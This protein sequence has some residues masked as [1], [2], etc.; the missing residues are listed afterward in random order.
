M[1][2]SMS[3]HIVQGGRPR[4][5][6]QYVGEGWDQLERQPSPIPHIPQGLQDICEVYVAE[7]WG[8]AV[9]VR[10]VHVVQQGA[11]VADSS[12][13]RTF[14]YVHVKGIGHDPAV[15]E[16]RL[17]PH[18]GGFVEPVEHVG[19]VAVPT[20][21]CEVDPERD[22]VL[23]GFT[24]SL[25]RPLPLVMR[26][27]DGLDTR[28]RSRGDDEEGSSEL[29]REPG[30]LTQINQ[31]SV[32]NVLVGVGEVTFGGEVRAHG[33][34]REPSVFGELLY[35]LR[36]IRL[37]LH[38]GLDGVVSEA[39]EAV[40]GR[41][42]VLALEADD[43]VRI[44]ELLLHPL[45]PPADKP[46]LQDGEQDDDG[47]D[48]GDGGG[49]R[50]SPRLAE[51]ALERQEAR[52]YGLKVIVLDEGNG[53]EKLVPGREPRDERNGQEAWPAQGQHDAE[54]DLQFVRAVYAGC[55][56]EVARQSDEI[57]AQQ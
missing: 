26:I 23:A 33:T 30:D 3:G 56:L 16:A 15:R 25:Y 12:W 57:G 35:P 43:V 49:A 2:Y 27:G 45:K 7:A 13:D 1:G 36:V 53:E 19:A 29:G 54:Q 39:G 24:Y 42:D 8:E 32:S 48:Y 5:V 50:E 46:T 34:D 10:E 31:G 4:L 17:P 22:G 28:V 52:R 55:V 37:R 44:A 11:E 47:Q 21:Q 51:V 38:F 6:L 20:L 14:L 40:N 41:R 9:G 18:P